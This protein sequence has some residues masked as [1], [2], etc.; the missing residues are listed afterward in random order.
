MRRRDQ[1]TVHFG[2]YRSAKGVLLTITA[3]STTP[4]SRQ[5]IGLTEQDRYLLCVPLY[6]TAGCGMGALGCYRSGATIIMQS[7]QFDALAVMEAIERERVTAFGGV[8]TM[9]VAQLDHRSFRGSISRAYA[10]HGAAALQ[11]RS[12]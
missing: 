3:S 9:L 8:P 1:H 10:S 6:H 12:D 2:H 11:S 7:A 4:R 5:R